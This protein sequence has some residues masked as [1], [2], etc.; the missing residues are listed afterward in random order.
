MAKLAIVDDNAVQRRL[1]SAMLEK[2]HSVT[3]FESGEALLEA[4]RTEAE[5]AFDL[6]L[7]DIEMSGIDGY[8]T[9]RRLRKLERQP[10]TPVIFVSA[11]DAAPERVA[12]YQ[13]G[14]DDFVVK[15]VSVRELQHKVDIVLQHRAEVSSLSDQS[16]LARQV[17]FTAMTSMGELGVLMEFMRRA[18][19]STDNGAIADALLAALEA[20]GLQGA[21]Q[22]RGASGTLE[23]VSQ[24]QAAPLQAAV[25]ASL[26]DIGRVFILGSR[27]IVNYTH[28][29]LLVNNL[30]ADDAE[31]L[32][33]LRDNLTLLTEA[34]ETR[35]A[36][37]AAES[38]V[39]SL[40]ADAAHTLVSLQAILADAAGRAQRARENNHQYTIELLD[41]LIRLIE[42]YN[43]TEIQRETLRDLIHEGWEQSLRLQEDAALPEGDFAHVIAMLEKLASNKI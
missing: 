41:T 11:H 42:S 39:D 43:L 2:A 13:A 17:A 40:Q 30:P 38:T 34:A 32:G 8:E 4:L 1:L 24:Q 22:V 21:A 14:G 3:V 27:G 5:S 10:D 25:M 16:R 28:V 31:R 9:C 12:A 37:L 6:V 15:P 36:A 19:S 29:S 20:Y 23:R 18:A 33:R 26:R 35:L 7:L